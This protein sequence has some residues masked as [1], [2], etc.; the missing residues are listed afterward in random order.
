[1]RRD[2][3][4]PQQETDGAPHR[5]PKHG[6]LIDRHAQ[7]E[8]GN[9]GACHAEALDGE[10]EVAGNARRNAEGQR[11]NGEGDGTATLRCCARHE[12][13]EHHCKR[14]VII[15]PFVGCRFGE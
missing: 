3:L 7:T 5:A 13:T 6:R 14:H 12:T 4:Q 9:A 1:M 10:G 2:E 11:H 15:K 8:D